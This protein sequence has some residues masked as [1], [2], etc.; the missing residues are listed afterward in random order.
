METAVQSGMASAERD[1]HA[2]VALFNGASVLIKAN[3][4]QETAQKLLQLYLASPSGTEEAPTF[5]AHVWMAR[6]KAQS[7]DTSGAREE[8]AEALALANGYKPAQEL[9]F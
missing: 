4:D 5:V 1:R 6:L 7:G 9:K 2:S 8:R 3:R